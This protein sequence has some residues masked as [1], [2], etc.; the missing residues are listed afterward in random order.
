M[1]FS[2]I[3]PIFLFARSTL[4]FTGDENKL[5]LC[6]VS[7]FKLAHLRTSLEDFMHAHICRLLGSA[8]EFHTV[9]RE[10]EVGHVADEVGTVICCEIMKFVRANLVDGLV[11]RRFKCRFELGH[12]D[13]PQLAM[14]M[15]SFKPDRRY[16]V[17]RNSK[18]PRSCAAERSDDARLSATTTKL[19]RDISR[20]LSCHGG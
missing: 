6:L 8:L 14:H 20:L 4:V 17:N 12:I 5:C 15:R 11:E 10:V 9:E 7:V 2:G 13:F 19:R 18:S 16:S 3:F 1:C